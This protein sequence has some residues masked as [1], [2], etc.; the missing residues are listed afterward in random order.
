MLRSSIYTA[1]I[2]LLGT[3]AFAQGDLRARLQPITSP[4]KYAGVYHLGT[5]TWTRAGQM[6][7]T[8]NVAGV[9]AIYDNTCNTG[10]YGGMAQNERWFDEGRLPS[11]TSIV[12]PNTIGVPGGNDSEVGTQ[13]SYQI[14]GFQLGYC[15]FNTGLVSVNANFY[16]AYTPCAV[17]P[18]TAA[19]AFNVTGLPGGTAAGAQVCWL[20]DLDLCGVSAS[21]NMLADANGT[22]EGTTGADTFGW[23]I[24]WASPSVA[25]TPDGPILAGGPL[26]G[27]TYSV[28]AGSDGTTFDTGVASATY[29]ANQDGVA[30]ACGTLLPGATPE[31]GTGMGTADQFRIEGNPA[32]APGCY[33]FGGNPIASFHMQL[34]SSNVTLPSVSPLTVYCEAGVGGVIACPCAN[35]PAGPARG[36]DNSLATGGSQLNATGS[37]SLATDT[38]VFT[39]NSQTNNGTTILL[40]GTTAIAAGVNFGQG[41]RCVGG[42]LKRLYVKSPGGTGGITAP[43]GTTDLSVSARSSALGDIITAGSTRYYMAYY[44]DPIV[45]GGCA[46]TSTFNASHAGSVVWN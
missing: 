37:A 46:A 20:L 11:T 33:F 18:A 32:A 13:N 21:F 2:V 12:L 7:Q 40:Q 44:R 22:Y 35:P 42:S 43:N 16:E 4:V 14:D 29:P 26:V 25:A 5:G 30:L 6:G 28:C 39:T 24:Q 31:Q 34:Y 38:L 45:L 23:T 36:C 15:S 17:A 10:Y 1:G 27:G 41:V 3:T 19:A 9:G 8:A